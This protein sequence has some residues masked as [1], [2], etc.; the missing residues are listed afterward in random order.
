FQ[1]SNDPSHQRPSHQNGSQTWDGKESCSK[2]QPP[3][4]APKGAHLAPIFHAVA[5]VVETDYMLFGMEIPAHDRQ[6]LHIE[7]G[8]M[9]FLDGCFR[10]D[11]S[12]V[13][14]N[15]RIH[16]RY[17]ITLGH[18]FS[19]SWMFNVISP[20]AVWGVAFSRRLVRFASA[21]G[22]PPGP[23]QHHPE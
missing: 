19:F 17:G 6:F 23:G 16:S 11:V 7:S 1:P 20:C 12:V 18:L 21:N 4:T 22:P 14:G 5:G 3:D 13:G 8:P 9:K 2:Q 10:P 15:Q